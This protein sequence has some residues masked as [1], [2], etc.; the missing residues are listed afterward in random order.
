M[1]T[2]RS[3]R[4]SVPIPASRSRARR[5][6]P[7]NHDDGL[8]ALL[9]LAV[10][11]AIAQFGLVALSLVDT[12]AIGR[13]SVDDLA[14]AGIGRSIGFGT[15][16]VGIGV[17]TGLEPLAAQAI[18]AG[19]H[20]RAWQGFVTNLRATLLVWPPLMAAAFAVT[21][22]LPAA[23]AGAAGHHRAC[24]CTSPDRRRASRRCWRSSRPRRS[25]RRTVARRPRS[26]GSLVANVMNLPV[27]NVLVRGDGALARSVCAR[28]AC[29]RWA[30][31]AAASRSASRASSCWPS[32]PSRRCEY[33]TK[34]T[35]PRPSAWRPP[36][37]SVCP[38][39]LQM[40]VEVGRLLDRRAPVGALGPEVAS[41]HHVAIGMASFTFMARH[42]RERRDLRARGLRDRRGHLAAPARRRGHRARRGGHDRSA[43]PSS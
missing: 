24:A 32:W 43:P 15:M 3:D 13:V 5:A 12:A 6:G 40:F 41:A 33:R 20:G 21:L 37:A 9:R 34:A 17:A 16:I 14:G 22:A 35:T 2:S 39:G 25:C 11:I 7:R 1:R 27:S 31:S 29:P 36:T 10:P 28:W 23:R 30:P 4:P 8:E 26:L 18:G 38:S 19:E 42:G